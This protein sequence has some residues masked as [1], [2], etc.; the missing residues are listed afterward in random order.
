MTIT[1][2]ISEF[3][4][5]PIPSVLKSFSPCFLE[6]PL[7]QFSTGLSA[8]IYHFTNRNKKELP[9]HKPHCFN[10]R[11]KSRQFLRRLPP[12][13]VPRGNAEKCFL[14]WPLPKCPAHFSPPLGDCTNSGSPVCPSLGQ[15]RHFP[16]YQQP[17]LLRPSFI[18]RPAH[19]LVP[20]KLSTS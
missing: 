8:I 5:S 11:F 18:F 20:A 6:Q 7:P 1:G 15:S 14:P 19:H 12:T 13:Q 10:P 16:S 4:S 2:A 3:H 9:K 17:A